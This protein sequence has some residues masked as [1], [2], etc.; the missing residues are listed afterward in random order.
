MSRAAK[1]IESYEHA[2]GPMP[3][4]ETS[5]MQAGEAP[6]LTP[7]GDEAIKRVDTFSK[8]QLRELNPALKWDW[9]GRQP[10]EQQR[11]SGNLEW[12]LSVNT[13]SHGDELVNQTQQWAE[14][15]L[16]PAV[17]AEFGDDTL[18]VI[19]TVESNDFPKEDEDG[20]ETSIT[21]VNVTVRLMDMLAGGLLAPAPAK[22]EE[23]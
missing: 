7:E 12:T 16:K 8:A 14:E 5:T 4:Q 21:F 23:E 20:N 6:I 17:E 13:Q 9:A 18:T 10:S 15:T 19:A 22:S 3:E 2:Y 1:L 11:K